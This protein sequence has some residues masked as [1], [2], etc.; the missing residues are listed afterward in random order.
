MKLFPFEKFTVRNSISKEQT[1][2]HLTNSISL[3]EK[4]GSIKVSR[5][6]RELEGSVK[7]GQFRLR[8]IPKFGYNAFLPIITGIIMEGGNGGSLIQIEIKPQNHIVIFGI[9]WMIFT[10]FLT[11]QKHL[12]T[13]EITDIL[14]VGAPYIVLTIVFNIE[15]DETKVELDRILNKTLPKV[16]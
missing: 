12:S 9:G 13:F 6:L 16:E 14:F 15:L 3:N 8:R 10:V 2:E 5:S 4:M 1:E 7:N 11:I